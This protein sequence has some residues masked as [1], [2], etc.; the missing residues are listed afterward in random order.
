MIDRANRRCSV[1]DGPGDCC[2]Q[3]LDLETPPYRYIGEHARGQPT[4]ADRVPLSRIMSADVVCAR[5][6]L[7]IAGVVSLMIRHHIGCIPVVDDR[8]HPIGMIT[9]FDIVEQLDAFMRSSHRG[10]PMPADLAART[11]DELMMPLAMTLDQHASIAHA[12]A[13]MTTEDLHHVVVVDDRGLLVGIVSTKDI[14]TWLA[15]NDRLVPKVHDQG[16]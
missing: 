2:A 3:A 14:A 6:T 11:A 8:R 7:E 13:L 12:A 5:P 9:K 10:S 4:N 15:E 1:Y 16:S